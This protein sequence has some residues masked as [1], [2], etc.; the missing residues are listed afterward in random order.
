MYTCKIN[1]AKKVK[2]E[3][4][5]ERKQL[6]LLKYYKFRK[7]YKTKI[8]VMNIKSMLVHDCQPTDS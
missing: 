2:R 5:E 3:T 6:I 4:E 1:E 8:K 7:S